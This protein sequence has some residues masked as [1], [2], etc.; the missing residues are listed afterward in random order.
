MTALKKLQNAMKQYIFSD[1]VNNTLSSNIG[2][3][4]DR[5]NIYK[6]NYK[7]TLIDTLSNTFPILEYVL[8]K[9]F[10]RQEAGLFAFANPPRESSLIFYGKDFGKC[11]QKKLPQYKFIKDVH[12]LDWS[13]H[14]SYHE[15]ELSNITGEDCIPILKPSCFLMKSKHN[16]Y[17]I[18][19][20]YLTKNESEILPSEEQFLFIY[21]KNYKVRVER[22]GEHE[23]LFLSTLKENPLI[24]DQHFNQEDL[25]SLLISFIK[26]D[27]ISGL[28]ECNFNK[29]KI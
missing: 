17:G 14:L 19:E 26:R 12:N 18:Y 6:N 16:L 11:I 24:L 22:I 3:N 8:G 4:I 29:L 10:F 9:K 27:C 25:T 1:E 20:S 5:L 28:K 13:M 23:Y 7:E 2:K 21:R 15:R